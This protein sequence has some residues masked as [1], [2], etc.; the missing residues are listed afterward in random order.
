MIWN[1]WKAKRLLEEQVQFL[2]KANDSLQNDIKSLM[3]TQAE[4]KEKIQS[5]S[6]QIDQEE[7]FKNLRKEEYA[8]YA[9]AAGFVTDAQNVTGLE[10]VIK[11]LVKER[12]EANKALVNLQI[13]AKSKDTSL[14]TQLE[15]ITKLREALE[16][17]KG[18]NETLMKEKGEAQD[19]GSNLRDRIAGLESSHKTIMK[20]REEAENI[21]IEFKAE[22]EESQKNQLT[23][24]KVSIIQGG[25]GKWYCTFDWNGFKV[26]TTGRWGTREKLIDALQKVGIV[27]F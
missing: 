14:K 4:Q 26:M 22:L 7:K 24:P 10:Q 1:P 12:D 23:R 6:F 15:T 11:D 27:L 16:K 18:F 3:D 9:G 8:R 19:I 21:A 2:E 13:I 17:E 20:H 25:K 5:L